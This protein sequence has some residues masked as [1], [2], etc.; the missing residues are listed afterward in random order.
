MNRNEIELLIERQKLNPEMI[1]LANT[2]TQVYL[3]KI[4]KTVEKGHLRI[5]GDLWLDS[6]IIDIPLYNKLF[7]EDNL[8]WFHLRDSTVLSLMV[9]NNLEYQGFKITK[10]GEIHV[11]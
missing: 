8:K 6:E 3:N 11:I 9:K 5:F 10:E 1:V 7:P 4:Q 2:I